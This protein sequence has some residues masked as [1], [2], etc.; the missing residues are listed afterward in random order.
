MAAGDRSEDRH[1]AVRIRQMIPTNKRTFRNSETGGKRPPCMVSRY[2]R[3]APRAD[4]QLS[5]RSRLRR[6]LSV[7]KGLGKGGAIVAG[8]H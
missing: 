5:A 4:I 8:G 2:S 7:T 1:L 6:R 3:F